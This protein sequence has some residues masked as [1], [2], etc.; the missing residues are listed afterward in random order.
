MLPAFSCYTQD[1]ELLLS[2]KQ[3]SH[4]ATVHCALGYWKVR[5]D[6]ELPRVMAGESRS[7]WGMPWSLIPFYGT[8]QVAASSHSI[9]PPWAARFLQQCSDEAPRVVQG[10]VVARREGAEDVS[11]LAR[12]PSA[13]AVLGGAF[14][15]PGGGHKAEEKEQWQA[16]PREPCPEAH[17]H[18]SLAC[19]LSPME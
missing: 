10:R 2:P 1:T 7:L 13:A 12:T 5:A 6:G 11:Q 3:G 18:S 14:L 15:C 16:A 17:F 8:D 19:R 9:G 4:E